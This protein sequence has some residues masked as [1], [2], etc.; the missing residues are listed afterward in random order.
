MSSWL[1]LATKILCP[2]TVLGESLALSVTLTFNRVFYLATID[3][4]KG[5]D[6]A[7]Y[8]MDNSSCAVW[9]KYN[10]WDKY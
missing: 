7:L 1:L 2:I 9:E 5:A 3:P 10:V 4:N 8:M 6:F